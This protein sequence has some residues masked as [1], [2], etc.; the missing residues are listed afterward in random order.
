MKEDGRWGVLRVADTGKGIPDHI[1]Q[2]IFEE[3]F[4]TGGTGIGLFIVKKLTDILG[5]AISVYD[6]EP[7]GTIF[8][9][10]FKAV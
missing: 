7:S 3:G 4:T 6:N 1:K 5:G 10:R 2:R 9:V 8:E